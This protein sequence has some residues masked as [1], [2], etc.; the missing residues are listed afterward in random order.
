MT[1]PFKSRY[2][3]RGMCSCNQVVFKSIGP[4]ASLIVQL[5]KL[6]ASSSE[7]PI[8]RQAL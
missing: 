2:M 5:H 6:L 1:E 7:F 8:N 4:D 3:H